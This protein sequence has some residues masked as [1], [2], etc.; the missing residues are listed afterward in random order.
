MYVNTV[1]IRWAHLLSTAES[2]PSTKSD[3]RAGIVSV[4]K[5]KVVSILPVELAEAVNFAYDLSGRQI[6]VVGLLAEGRDN[7]FIA[8]RMGI[9]ESTVKQYITSIMARLRV[10]SRLQIGRVGFAL[11]AVSLLEIAEG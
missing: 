11:K 4:S 2:Q 5:A 9:S 1:L 10:E 7:R 3:E 6:E 8:M